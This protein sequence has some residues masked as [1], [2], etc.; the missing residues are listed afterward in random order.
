M[1]K[2]GESA[3]N[4]EQEIK[5]RRTF[6]I[7]SHPD[8]GK[9][10]ITEKL[11]LYGGAIQMAGTVKAKRSKKFASS[12]WMEI[13]RKRGISVTSSVMSFPYQGC[14]INLIDTPGHQDFSEDTYR[15]L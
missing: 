12:D 6:A 1:A 14:A 13:E 4:L 9:T 7:I 3:L 8:A 10:T 11:L 15:T 2:S 5:K